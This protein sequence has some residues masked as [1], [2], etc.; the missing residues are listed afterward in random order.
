[1]LFALVCHDNPEHTLRREMASLSR[2]GLALSLKEN[3]TREK[4]QREDWVLSKIKLAGLENPYR[5]TGSLYFYGSGPDGKAYPIDLYTMVFEFFLRVREETAN[6][7]NILIGNIR[8][9]EAAIISIHN[10]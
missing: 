10:L 8:S 5:T 3:D 1:M 4:H 2:L 6:V 9:R 7:N